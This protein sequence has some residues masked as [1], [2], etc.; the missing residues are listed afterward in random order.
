MN[1]DQ[2]STVKSQRNNITIPKRTPSSTSIK[3]ASIWALLGDKITP[4]F[5]PSHFPEKETNDTD[6][7]RFFL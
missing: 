2:F 1:L 7:I 3:K 4:V 6:L 5:R